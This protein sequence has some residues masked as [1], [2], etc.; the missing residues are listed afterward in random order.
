MEWPKEIQKYLITEEPF[1]QPVKDEI[2]IFERAFKNKIGVML[3]G[4]TGCGKTRFVEHMFYRLKLPL[5]TTACNEDTDASDLTGRY[6]LKGQEGV[7]LDG[8]L[9]LPVRHGGGSY[10][11]EIVEARQDVMVLI[12][13]LTDSRRM[14]HVPKSGETLYAPD[15]FMLVVSFNPGYQAMSK[16]LKQSTRQRFIALNFDYPPAKLEIEIVKKESGLGTHDSSTLVKIAAEIRGMKAG[17]NLEEGA[18]TRLLIYAAQLIK[19]GIKMRRAVEVAMRDPITD[20]P[21]ISEAIDEHI[22]NLL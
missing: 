14:L 1:Y 16:A 9:T 20:D 18:S 19:D 8:S 22:D 11:D 15:N 12:H 10:L 13:S 7:W 4:P 3:K 2:A 6:V 21:S 17:R 5:V